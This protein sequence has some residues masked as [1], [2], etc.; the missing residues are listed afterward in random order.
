MGPLWP[1]AVFVGLPAAAFI[2]PDIFGGHLLMT[3]DN[4]QQNYPLH[5]LVGSMYRHGE[6]P[7]WNQYLFSGTPLLAGFNAGAF[8]PLIGLFAILPD[9]VA[10]IATEVIL[11]SLIAIGMYLFLRALKLSTI[12]CVLAAVAFSFS[13]VVLSQINH[14]D[15]T[16]GFASL[17][18]MLLAVVHIVRDGRWRWSVLLG[19]SFALVI[20]AGAPEAMLDEAFLVIIYAALCAGLDR[21]SWR[22][23]LTRCS[24]SV[25][26][27]LCLSAAQWLPG[28]AAISNSQRSA[29]G[30]SFT[31]SGSFAPANS[32]LSLV[33]YLFGGY[34]HLG[35]AKFFSHY[36]LPEVG[37]YVGILPVIALLTL[38]RPQWPSRLAARE[39]RIWYIIALFGLLLA[40]GANTPLEHVFNEIPLYGRQRL[41]SRN[42]IDV[43]V[44]VC[45]LFAGWLDRG[46]DPGRA[47]LKFERC[48][49]FI[50]FGVV[51]GVSTWAAVAPRS[52]VTSLT[53]A[54]G[55][56]IE[57]HTVREAS[58][59]ALGFCLVA[60][61]VTWLRSDMGRRP[62]FVLVAAF[63]AADLGLIL[64]TSSVL[65]VP[66]NAL[67]SGTTVVE[68]Y[69][70]AHMAPG[71]RFVFYDPQG[72][73]SGST[74]A[75]TGRPDANVLARLPSVGGYA[76]I[77]DG[78]YNSATLTHSQGELNVPRL[79]TGGF[80]QL[81]LQDILTTPEYFL[82]PLTGAPTQMG[83]VTQASEERGQDAV[84]PL[85]NRADFTDSGYPFYPA[86][87]GGIVAGQ[88]SRWF[89][90]ESLAASHASVLLAP[91]AT[92]ARIR[93]GTVTSRGSTRWAA[94]VGVA[95]GAAKCREPSAR[96]LRR[97][98]GRPSRFGSPSTPPSGHRSGNADLRDGWSTLRRRT[99]RPMAPG[100]F[101]RS[102]HPLRAGAST[103]PRLCDSDGPWQPPGRRCPRPE[104]QRRVHSRPCSRS[105]RHRARCGMGRRMAS[106]HLLQRRARSERSCGKAWSGPTGRGPARHRCHPLLVS[107][108]ALAR[109]Q[110]A[111]RRSCAV[112][113]GAPLRLRPPSTVG[114]LGP[115]T[116]SNQ[117][118]GWAS[119]R[120]NSP[121]SAP[122]ISSITKPAAASSSSIRSA[123]NLALISVR[124]SS[125]WANRT[126]MPASRSSTSEGSWARKRISIHWSASFHRA[127]CANRSGS[128]FPPS[129]S[130][131]TWRTFLL[132]CAVTPAASS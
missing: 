35:E 23:V 45:V 100:G 38:W 64:G 83:E 126:E 123:V 68:N 62:W 121:S 43:S 107:A 54:S 4:L 96:R 71:G 103:E 15:M 114:P 57:V 113:A 118:K 65:T 72:Y 7:F 39:R 44:A 80:A 66:S 17:P 127:T 56:T 131:R 30:T 132:N 130:L 73:S 3:G 106:L 2:L 48:A 13:G 32:L 18:F 5:V 25:A 49:G 93:F 34:G 74:T 47:S 37:I 27:A 90:G 89:F 55:S 33:P 104:R 116:P 42:M 16:E 20:F 70:A 122:H 12:P 102:V 98:P 101:H 29:L 128:K 67:L 28:I 58:L 91:G 8:Y 120:R 105:G 92:M 46:E 50:P 51:L 119:V 6:L 40:F 84:L 59:V 22:R 78:N 86:P 61:I 26:L 85:G 79:A 88:S 75:D 69:V 9:R 87:R 82:V 36:N 10:W 108:P 115:P 1:Y 63:M 129:C 14:V 11:F 95:P 76:S 24:A 52:L 19:V 109:G 125:P 60:G 124:M 99:T 110:R 117:Q 112:P 77:V 111:Q 21:R 41:Q 53:T 81:D 31:G 97:R 94:P